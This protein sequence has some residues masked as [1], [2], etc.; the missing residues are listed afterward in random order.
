MCDT[1]I[2]GYLPWWVVT[3]GVFAL[4]GSFPRDS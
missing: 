4:V 3:R 2:L 1:N